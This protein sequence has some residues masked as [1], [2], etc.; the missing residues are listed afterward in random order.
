[1]AAAFQSEKGDVSCR[2]RKDRPF[3]LSRVRE[4]SFL[5]PVRPLDGL[6]LC[7]HSQL[8]GSVAGTLR[9]TCEGKVVPSKSWNVKKGFFYSELREY[10]AV[11]RALVIMSRH[12]GT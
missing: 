5:H 1:M 9:F 10:P 12:G 2:S 8:T 11:A 6:V 4:A 7:V 3:L